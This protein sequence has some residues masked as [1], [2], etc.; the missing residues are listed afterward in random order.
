M[1][2]SYTDVDAIIAQESRV[3]VTF[4]VTATGTAAGEACTPGKASD[5][6]NVQTQGVRMH[7]VVTAR[8]SSRCD[9][10]CSAGDWFAVWFAG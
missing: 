5:W 7:C 10:A 1:P 6:C 2:G 8:T 9:H 3:P 4:K